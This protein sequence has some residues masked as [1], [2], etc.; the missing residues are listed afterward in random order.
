VLISEPPQG[1]AGSTFSLVKSPQ[2]RFQIRHY[3]FLNVLASR[4][5]ARSGSR[6]HC[7]GHLRSAPGGGNYYHRRSLSA[8]RRRVGGLW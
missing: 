5:C 7:P 2:F 8:C 3:M 4:W 6:T 1:L